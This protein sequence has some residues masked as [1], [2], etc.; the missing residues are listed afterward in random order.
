MPIDD[1]YLVSLLT[2]LVNI[3]SVFPR[4]AEVMLFLEQVL[5][6]IGLPVERL[7][8]SDSRFNLLASIGKG[9]PVLC[10]NAHAD[11]VPTSG[12]STPEARVERN[13][14]YGLGS[15]D[16]K[17][18]IAAMITAVRAIHESR[19]RLNGR[20]DI[21]ISVDEEGDAM[22]VRT[23]VEEGYRCDIALVGEPTE[24][25][26]V[27]AHCGLIFLDLITYGKSAHG[28]MPFEGVNA[29][30]MAYELVTGLR[31][32]VAG[33]KPHPLLGPPSLNLGIIG[34]GDR[35][36]R[37]PDRCEASVDIRLV[38]PMTDTLVL[39]Q[40]AAYFQ[41]WLGRAEYKVTKRGGP[42]DTPAESPIVGTLHSAIEE[43]LGTAPRIA[44][45]RG[46]TEA[47]SF[48]S[49]LGIDTVVFGPGS[50]KQAHSGNEFVDLRQVRAAARVYA[51]T[52]LKLLQ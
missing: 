36:N 22:G 24:L 48:H 35:P 50:L 2:D 23:A 12:S 6:D 39:E 38:P 33:Y 30:D 28:S 15:A 44:S 43:V 25:E 14:L 8:L 11:T 7:P 34:G 27:R 3:P 9:S 26:I 45:W 51:Q 4:E 13:L 31:S 20:L 17:A 46:W 32:I 18:S 49:Q 10:L 41:G 5:V 47:E 16:D 40:I 52:A 42:L 21:L 1:A 29:I 19:A 37:V